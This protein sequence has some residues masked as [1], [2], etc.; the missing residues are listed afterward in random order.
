MANLKSRRPGPLFLVGWLQSY[1]R[2]LHRDSAWLRLG[3]EAPGRVSLPRGSGW[4]FSFTVTAA[5]AVIA[6]A[7]TAAITARGGAKIAE[8]ARDDRGP[9]DL[10]RWGERLRARRFRRSSE[11]QRAGQALGRH[12]IRL[13]AGAARRPH[14]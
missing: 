4:F 7:F 8:V 3:L 5:A 9:R 10:R 6:A 11:P 1:L 12:G 13:F 2:H 14:R